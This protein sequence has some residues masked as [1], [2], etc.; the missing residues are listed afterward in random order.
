LDNLGKNIR[1]VASG[2]VGVGDSAEVYAIGRTATAKE[3]LAGI[4]WQ[5]WNFS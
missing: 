2:V 5:E 3:R 4:K 1:T